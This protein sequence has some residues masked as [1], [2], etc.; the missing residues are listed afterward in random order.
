MIFINYCT[1]DSNKL[2]Y[3]FFIFLLMLYRRCFLFNYGVITIRKVFV[4]PAPESKVNDCK[5]FR[6]AEIFYKSMFKKNN[7]D[8]VKIW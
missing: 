2:V 4:K 1:V 8:V 5:K 7:D 3:Y 6:K